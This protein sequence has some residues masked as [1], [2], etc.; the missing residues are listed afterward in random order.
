MDEE[1]MTV[2]I[3]AMSWVFIGE[4]RSDELIEEQDSDNED[5]R[6]AREARE[7]MQRVRQSERKIK[8][9]KDREMNENEEKE[10]EMDWRLFAK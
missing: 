1:V 4:R 9:T 3:E 7:V 8:L 10:M 2:T 6:E 5:M